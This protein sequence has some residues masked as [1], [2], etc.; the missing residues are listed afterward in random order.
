[1]LGNQGIKNRGSPAI[2]WTARLPRWS[3]W[4][5]LNPRPHGPE[6]CAL[7]TALHPDSFCIIAGFSR[8]VKCRP[9]VRRRTPGRSNQLHRGREQRQDMRMHRFLKKPEQA[10]IACSGVPCVEEREA[11]I[12]WGSARRGGAFAPYER[13]AA[14]KTSAQGEFISPEHLKSNEWRTPSAAKTQKER[15]TSRRVFL[16]AMRCRKRYSPKVK[17]A[18]RAARQLR[19]QQSTRKG[20]ATSVKLHRVAAMSLTD[21]RRVAVGKEEQ[22]RE[23][24]LTFEKSRSKRY[25]ACSD[26][27][28]RNTIDA[29]WAKDEDSAF[30]NLYLDLQ[31]IPTRRFRLAQP[32]DPKGV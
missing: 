26:V 21:A 24:A 6:P 3:E 29:N 25:T 23:C 22:R 15:H 14:G 7:P 5:D 9:A 1:M 27:E 28:Y 16:F 30:T 20:H 31:L 12:G 11:G 19:A 13:F 8:P 32:K 18:R 10:H 2:P 17:A 4:R